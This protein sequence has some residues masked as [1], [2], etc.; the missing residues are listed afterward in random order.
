[1]RTDSHSRI[2]P[3][4]SYFTDTLPVVSSSSSMVSQTSPG[5]N[6]IASSSSDVC[7]STSVPNDHAVFLDRLTVSDSGRGPWS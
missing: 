5:S 7:S 3:F 2:I 6:I 4:S 1:M